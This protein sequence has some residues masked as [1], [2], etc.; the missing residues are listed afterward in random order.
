MIEL[1]RLSNFDLPARE[2]LQK[3]LKYHETMAAKDVRPWQLHESA[4]KPS[5]Q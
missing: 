5:L 3:Q 1:C 4:S 2:G